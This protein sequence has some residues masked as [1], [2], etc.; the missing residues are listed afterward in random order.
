MSWWY[1][2]RRAIENTPTVLVVVTSMHCTRSCAAL[3]LEVKNEGSVWPNTGSLVLENEDAKLT[4]KEHSKHHLAL[5]T[6]TAQ[7]LVS[8]SLPLTHS[9]LLQ[10]IRVRV[11]RER[12]IAW[13]GEA[14]RFESVR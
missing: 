5:V 13:T 8:W 14:G 2:F 4:L 12:P 1:R 9:H 7:S 6:E 10:G 3:I 11:N